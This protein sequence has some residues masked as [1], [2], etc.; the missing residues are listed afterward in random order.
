MGSCVAGDR[1]NG[2]IAWLE[3]HQIWMY[4]AALFAGGV[5]GILLP[6]VS[7]PLEQAINP[8]LG[9]LL[10]A[11]FLMVPLGRIGQGFKD[12]H[13]LG[14]L[15]ALNFLVVPI[16]VF[17]LTRF[18]AG[19]QVLLVGVVFV[20][21][22]PCIDYVIV[23]THFAGGAS[24]RL[25]S[26]TPLLMLGQMVLLPFYLWLFISA[27]FVR[28]VDFAPFAQAFV[29]LIILPLLAA[30]LT[31]FAAARTPWGK[32]LE[33]GVSAA[34]VPLM[35]ATLAIIVASQISGVSHQ[36][37]SLFKL[38]PLYLAFAAIM[39]VLGALISHAAKLNVPARRAVTFSGVTRN[40][41]VILPLVL[42]LPA[43]FALAPLVVVT[44]TL[45]ELCVMIMMI[46]AVPRIIK[47]AAAP[48]AQL[49]SSSQ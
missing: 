25:L 13:F 23:F 27:D 47:P 4:L 12:F 16:V 39:A 17:L 1:A 35:M 30:A 2:M 48:H 46:W 26:A 38:V 36:L 24:E 32:K 44:Q 45:V 11:T 29:L 22:A 37:V 3:K 34:M 9:L 20:L 14:V 6:G 41:L 18:I 10:Y 19:D 43:Q 15:G 42:A 8:V 28:T 40:S 33:E 49:P 21:L 7:T 5:I 31:Q